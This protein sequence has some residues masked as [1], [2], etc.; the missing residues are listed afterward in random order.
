VVAGGWAA[1]GGGDGFG[2]RRL[3][4]Q[5]E[6]VRMRPRVTEKLRVKGEGHVH[7]FKGAQ[8]KRKGCKIL[9]NPFLKCGAFM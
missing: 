3:G 7:R 2:L 9:L 6:S 5:L 4:L 1:S 8:G